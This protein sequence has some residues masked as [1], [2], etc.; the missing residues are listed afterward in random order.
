MQAATITLST[1][2]PAV[3]QSFHRPFH[4]GINRDSYQVVYAGWG[5]PPDGMLPADTVYLT[6][7][8]AMK[9]YIALSG[10]R[11][12]QPGDTASIER[13]LAARD[14]IRRKRRRQLAVV[15]LQRVL[16]GWGDHIDP[17]LGQ[18]RLDERGRPLLNLPPEHITLPEEDTIQPC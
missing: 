4:L 14:E 12:D 3:G 10:H 6:G 9:L 8:P 16:A 1:T 15:I 11:F 2:R 13:A 7:K 5:R 17:W 18:V